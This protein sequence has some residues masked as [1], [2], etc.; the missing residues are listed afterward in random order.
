M[1]REEA[2]TGFLW[3]NLREGD[4]LRDMRRW[5]DHN[6]MD[7][8]EVEYGSGHWIELVQDRDR[9]RALVNTVM[10]FRVP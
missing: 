1:G 8:R 9:W 3:E 7:I 2:C 10:N 5:E 6:K 4:Q